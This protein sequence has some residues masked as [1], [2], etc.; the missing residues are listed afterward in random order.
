MQVFR[1]LLGE[2]LQELLGRR[3][4]ADDDGAA[5]QLAGAGQVVRHQSDREALGGDRQ[6]AEEG[7]VAEPGAVEEGRR[8][9]E[10][11]G[12]ECR[13]QHGEPGDRDAQSEA[14]RRAQRRDAVAAERL[15]DD[16]DQ[17]RYERDRQQR[18][19]REARFRYDDG[20]VGRQ[21]D[22]DR[23][24]ELS[25]PH[26]PFEDRRRDDAAP[27]VLR[28]RLRQLVEL[29]RVGIDPPGRCRRRGF[30]RS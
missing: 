27:T 1:P 21:P 29:A 2:V 19:D 15:H 18:Q 6:E 12:G 26:E 23:Q 20:E 30:D 22:G 8:V 3:A 5:R 11:A 9:G 4:S 14:R 24:A 7:P 28:H 17:R 16:D 10:P 13:P 25:Q